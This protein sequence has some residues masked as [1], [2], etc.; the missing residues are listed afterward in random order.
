MRRAPLVVATIGA[1]LGQAALVACAASDEGLRPDHASPDGSVVPVG[2]SG[3]EDASAPEGSAV[4]TGALRRCS[5]GGF[6][7]ASLPGNVRNLLHVSA[8]SMDDIWAMSPNAVLRGD[9]ASWN[10]VYG[11]AAEGAPAHFSG[12]WVSKKDDVW[13]LATDF[14]MPGNPVRVVR[15]SAINGQPPAFRATSIASVP[16]PYGEPDIH[17]VFGVTPGS[18]ALWLLDHRFPNPPD[19]LVRLREEADGTVV[20]DRVSIPVE[21]SDGSTYRWLSLWSFSSTDIYVGGSLCVAGHS[22]SG[23]CAASSDDPAEDIGVI[24]HYDGTTWSIASLGDGA[25]I[26]MYGT[27]SANQPRQL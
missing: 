10:T 6:C 27:K 2:E 24:A 9:G 20:S 13:L 18:D 12:L 5:T 21:E 19:S 4:D 1:L 7:Y 16:S 11:G 26:A 25:V 14:D 15:Y 23:R 3:L 22:F 8:S 17:P